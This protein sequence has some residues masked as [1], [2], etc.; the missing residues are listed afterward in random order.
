MFGVHSCLKC[1]I[2]LS[3]IRQFPGHDR[4]HSEIRNV[5]RIKIFLEIESGITNWMFTM[6]QK[7]KS[8]LNLSQQ[9]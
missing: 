9:D 1:P 8:A 3:D 6:N 5:Y 2:Y 4:D 7:L